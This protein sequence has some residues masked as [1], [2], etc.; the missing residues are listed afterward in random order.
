MATAARWGLKEAAGKTTARGTRS[1]YEATMSGREGNKIQSP[2]VIR[3]GMGVDATGI[4]GEGV[5]AIHGEICLLVP[6]FWDYHRREA[7]R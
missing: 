2:I 4:W 7:A 3:E 5:C 1:A 6:E